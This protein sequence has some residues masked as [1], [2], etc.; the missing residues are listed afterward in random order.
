[1]SDGCKISFSREKL[2]ALP[3]IPQLDLTGHSEAAKREGKGEKG[4]VIG[5]KGNKWRRRDPP[6]HPIYEFPVKAL[7]TIDVLA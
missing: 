3:Q 2:T 1:M 4:R 6:S 7:I 5:K